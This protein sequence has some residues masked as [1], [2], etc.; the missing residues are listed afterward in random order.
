M[1]APRTGFD[2]TIR[3]DGVPEKTLA[4]GCGVRKSMLSG[5][6]VL[7][8]DPGII[9]LSLGFPSPSLISLYCSIVSIFSLFTTLLPS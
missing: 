9:H 7:L 8:K 5:L 3:N 1:H 2:L 4:A 6:S